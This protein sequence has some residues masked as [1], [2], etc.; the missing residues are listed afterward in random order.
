MRRL[1]VAG[2]LLTAITVLAGVASGAVAY[3]P[4]E[5]RLRELDVSDQQVG[6]WR[7]LPGAEL[8]SANGYQLGVVLEQSGQHVLVELTELPAGASAEDQ[9]NVYHLCFEQTGTPGEVVDLDQRIRYAGDGSYGVRMTVSDAQDAST[10]CT[11]ANPASATGTFTV[12][13]H[14]AVRRIGPR[15]LVLN[16]FGGPRKFS[17]WAIDRPELG[18]FPELTCATNAVVQPDGSLAGTVE[19]TFPASRDRRIPNEPYVVNYVDLEQPGVWTCV[20]RQYQGGGLIPPPWSAPT[21]PELVRELWAGLDD[22]VIADARPP[23]FAMAATAEDY[24]AGAR[25]KLRVFRARCGRKP[26]G[27]T[28]TRSRVRSNGK[29]RFRFR[30]PRLRRNEEAAVFT[31]DSTASGSRLIVPRRR[32]EPNLALVRSGSRATLHQTLAGCA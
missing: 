18:G 24:H 25:V 1:E 20:G 32:S 5:M 30:L 9:R 3:S 11:T 28:A 29:V 31:T 7:P 23:R 17:G 26:K 10:G 16:P 15:P 13:T 27:V 2:A 6:P 8:A 14:T 4:P 12:S 19:R 22:H 21:E